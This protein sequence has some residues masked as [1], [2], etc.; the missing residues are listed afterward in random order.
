MVSTVAQPDSELFCS[1]AKPQAKPERH[2]STLIPGGHTSPLRH[3]TVLRPGAGQTHAHHARKSSSNLS[4]SQTPRPTGQQAAKPIYKAYSPEA[5]QQDPRA[6]LIA[7]EIE[8]FFTALDVPPLHIQKQNEVSHSTPPQSPGRESPVQRC[9]SPPVPPKVKLEEEAQPCRTGDQQSPPPR[10]RT[11]EEEDCLELEAPPAYDENER[12]SPPPEKERVPSHPFS[13]DEDLPAAASISAAQVGGSV[14]G[15]SAD[16]ALAP[17]TRDADT[18]DGD[19][20]QDDEPNKEAG[21]E[22]I[23]DSVEANSPPPLPPRAAFTASSSER[24]QQQHQVQPDSQTHMP[25]EF[26]PPPKR[27]PSPRSSSPQIG[28]T[29]AA[30]SSATAVGAA[31]A[32]PSSDFA[33]NGLRQTRIAL[34]KHMKHMVDKAKEH[35]EQHLAKKESVTRS[36]FEDT[37]TRNILVIAPI[38]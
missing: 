29:G 24:Q 27:S 6:S 14:A 22:V 34:G 4:S 13:R 25:G 3:P 7:S 9:S 8:G 30:A 16:E 33:H 26:P 12:V 37:K 20:S 36:E 2:P 11:Q 32:M 17:K 19:A 21:S 31:V 35:H 28:A 18:P 1:T 38:A 5:T 15:H 23:G 10:A